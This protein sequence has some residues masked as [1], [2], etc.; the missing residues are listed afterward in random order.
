M[1]H[2]PMSDLARDGL[3]IVM[4]SCELRETL[5]MSDRIAVM[6]GRTIIGELDCTG[7]TQEAIL[8]LAPGPPVAAAALTA[9]L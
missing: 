2:R 5:G 9:R 4:I 3:A 1:I 8:E 7:A 6:H